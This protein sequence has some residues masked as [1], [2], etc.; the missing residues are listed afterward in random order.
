MDYVILILVPVCILIF[1][2]IHQ[3]IIQFGE[4]Y[5]KTISQLLPSLASVSQAMKNAITLSCVVFFGGVIGRTFTEDD[6]WLW[7]ALVFSAVPPIVQFIKR[8]R[9]RMSG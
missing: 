5:N 8:K 2:V 7:N 1:L 3:D 9:K 6:R 4:R